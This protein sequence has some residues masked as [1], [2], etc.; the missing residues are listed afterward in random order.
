[1]VVWSILLAL[2]AG[3]FVAGFLWVF[4]DVTGLGS[5]RWAPPT[6]SPMA[7]VGRF[8]LVW[9]TAVGLSLLMFPILQSAMYRSVLE[10]RARS[11]AYLR[12]GRVEVGMMLLQLLFLAFLVIF[13]MGGVSA[14]VAV[15]WSPLLLW[16]KIAIGIAIGLGCLVAWLFVGL[17]LTLAGP[18]LVATGRLDL[19]AAWRLSRGRF[20]PLLAMAALAMVLSSAVSTFAQSIL[21][22]AMVP[23]LRP[24]MA[25]GPH[26]RFDIS[27]LRDLAPWAALATLIVG[28]IFAIQLVIWF[29]P[30]SA[31][32]K[33][34]AE[35]NQADAVH[36]T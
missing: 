2:W 5:S 30:F 8:L 18:L 34:L 13:Y 32:Y 33:S 15:S 36:P 24:L 14:I 21:N 31:L 23:F 16:A 4:G 19:G 11:F 20:S 9:L 12:L 1:M 27:T 10:P 7:I 6:G 28:L 29:A 3:A 22:I 26:P 17:R 35:D 25:G